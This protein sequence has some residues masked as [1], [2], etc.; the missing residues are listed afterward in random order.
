MESAPVVNKICRFILRV[1]WEF[2]PP[3][4]AAYLIGHVWPQLL[5]FGGW[6]ST[7]AIY[8]LLNYC[9]LQLLRIWH[10]QGQRADLSKVGSDIAALHQTTS[11]IWGAIDSLKQNSGKQA[12]AEINQL[13]SLVLKADKEVREANTA[14]Q[15]VRT[16]RD[17]YFTGRRG[18]ANVYVEARPKGQEGRPVE[19]YAVE[20]HADHVLHTARTQ[21]EAIQWAKSQGYYPLVARVRHLINKNIPDHWRSA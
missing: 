9:W 15:S 1:L 5:S 19:D 3:A 20:D 11:Q 7:S 21:Q 17:S 13:E 14:Y 16:S 6:A 12:E 8:V 4:F 10:Q 2:G 18:G